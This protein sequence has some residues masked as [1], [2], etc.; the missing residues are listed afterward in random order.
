MHSFAELSLQFDK[1]FS[2]RQF[3]ATPAILYDAASYIPQLGGKRVRP[4]LCLMSNELFGDIHPDS[5]KVA[6]ALEMFHSFSL[7]HDD[8]M[9]NAPLRR[10]KD[11]VHIK[12]GHSAAILAGDVML[13]R[14]YQYLEE[15]APALLT[16]IMQLFNRTAAEVCEGQQMD[17]E[18]EQP[19]MV[20]RVEDYIRMIELKTSVLLA[21]S[22]KVGA[23]MG[24][25]GPGNQQHL[26][27]FGRNLGIAF[28][29]QDDYLD[30]FGDPGK[31]GKQP[32]GDILAGKKTFLALHTLQHMNTAQKTQWDELMAP[33]TA[34]QQRVDGILQLYRDCGADK[35]ALQLKQ[36]YFG[37]CL[38]HLSD[39]A[40]LSSRKQPLMELA[41]SLM[42]REQ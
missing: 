31:F 1:Y 25:A 28:Q 9:D 38:Q 21:A 41:E 26:Y 20:V 22:L 19:G 24:G 5:W 3:P 37:H 30:A 4:I 6:A 10:G 15:I 39:A 11:T 7:V 23:I 27:E 14:S 29:V 13:V 34:P 8:I 32:G 40:V 16:P 42:A 33:G 2:R 36:E 17:M 18:F 12:F 35:W